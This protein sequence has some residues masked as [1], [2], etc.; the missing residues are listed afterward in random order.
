MKFKRILSPEEV[1]KQIKIDQR[2]LL[3]SFHFKERYI[4]F[5]RNGR[6]FARKPLEWQTQKVF[7]TI[8]AAIEECKAWTYWY[9]IRRQYW[10]ALHTSHYIL[11]TPEYKVVFYYDKNSSFRRLITYARRNTELSWFIKYIIMRVNK[12]LPEKFRF[13]L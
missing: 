6:K 9:A 8:S 12:F 1:K 2:W 4:Q 13:I 5:S 10:Q 7:F 3:L 11:F